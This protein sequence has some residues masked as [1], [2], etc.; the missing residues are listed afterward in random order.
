[1][2]EDY[3]QGPMGETIAE[4]AIKT[5]MEQS[6]ASMDEPETATPEVETDEQPES[7]DSDVEKTEVA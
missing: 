4:D 7:D 6:D 3:G 2:V 1:M 5:S